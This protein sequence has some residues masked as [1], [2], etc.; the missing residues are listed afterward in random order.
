MHHRP[1]RRA[2]L[3]IHQGEAA[4][5]GRAVAE[6]RQGEIQAKCH[7]SGTPDLTLFFTNAR[8]LGDDI[9]R[10][11]GHMPAATH[12]APCSFH[13]CVRLTRWTAER[14]ISFI[15]PDGNFVLGTYY[16]DTNQRIELPV[17]VR[18]TL[19]FDK[20]TRTGSSAPRLMARSPAAT[21]TLKSRRATPTARLSRTSCCCCPSRRR[22]R[23]PAP[24]PQRASPALIPC[25][26][27][28][29]S[30]H[31]SRCTGHQDVPLGDQEAAAG[32]AVAL[33]GPRACCAPHCAHADRTQICTLSADAI[34]E[35]SPSI[36]IS[37]KIPGFA[38]SQLK[39]DRLEVIEV[40]CVRRIVPNSLRRRS[41]SRSRASSTT[42]MPSRA[43]TRSARSAAAA[44]DLHGRC[45]L[46]HTAIHGT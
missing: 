2:S 25:A 43:A 20:A 13:P 32:Q 46:R 29:R 35:T 19:V 6:L 34:P 3:R 27:R 7:L 9:R 17:S 28:R 5:S 23:P 16:V 15:P 8:I 14:V 11:A 4:I 42:R 21:W 26:P 44:D 39:V 22:S 31:P 24:R 18:P 36:S 12:T 1:Q 30:R 40:V 10:A 38:A 37:F 45:E 41:T 33:Q